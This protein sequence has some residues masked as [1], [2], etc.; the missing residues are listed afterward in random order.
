[1]DNGTLLFSIS[2]TGMRNLVSKFSNLYA[3]PALSTSL[4]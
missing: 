1:M 3:L 2:K 4:V